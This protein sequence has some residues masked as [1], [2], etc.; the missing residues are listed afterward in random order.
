MGVVH[1]FENATGAWT[2]ATQPFAQTRATAFQV[3]EATQAVS[4]RWF[5]AGAGG[6]QAPTRLDI[7][8]S[9]TGTSLTGNIP[10]ADNGAVGWQEVALG[11]PVDLVAGRTYYV[12][13]DWATGD[14]VPFRGGG[15]FGTPPPPLA[16]AAAFR[17]YSAA[18]THG[19]PTSFDT[20]NGFNI[21]V[22]V[23]GSNVDPPGAGA[24]PT[25]LSDALAAWLSTTDGTH[26][27][28][29]PLQTRTI[30]GALEVALDFLQGVADGIKEAV[31]DEKPIID[32]LPDSIGDVLTKA[33][34]IETTLAE[35]LAGWVQ[36]VRDRITGTTDGGGSAF[37]GP[38]GTQVGA[39]VEALLARSTNAAVGF[40]ASPWQLDDETDFDTALAWDVPADLYVI[41][42]SDLGSNRV[43]TSPAGVEV[44]YRLAWWSPLNGGAARERRFCDFPT[45]HA[46]DPAG[47][48]P[49]I[50]IFSRAGASGH[51]QAW[52]LPV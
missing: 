41:T 32:A 16:F 51:V 28:S 17:G 25:D 21:D 19:I 26:A 4:I 9:I 18:G 13:G 5:R 44:S 23:V 7:W 31:D 42:F 11:V 6:A 37:Y 36:D 20:A 3:S 34:S 47:R 30:V 49:G 2:N 29:A 50:L 45:Y 8:D 46:I 40:P 52:T 43:N 38:D 22:G 24:T 27:D 10:P 48:M 14:N 33:T 35:W 39:G 12:S 15:S 1:L